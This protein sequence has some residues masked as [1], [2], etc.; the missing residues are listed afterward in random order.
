MCYWKE[1]MHEKSSSDVGWNQARSGWVENAESRLLS[2]KAKLEL[3]TLT[4]LELS[5]FSKETS[6]N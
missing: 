5:L 3:S 1:K 2:E 4:V 6:D